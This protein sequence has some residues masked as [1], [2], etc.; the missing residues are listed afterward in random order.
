LLS[1]TDVRG[2]LRHFAT[3]RGATA[4]H[5]RVM[6]MIQAVSASDELDEGDFNVLVG[7]HVDLA[8]R[9]AIT[10]LRDRGAAEDAVQDAALNAWRAL[11]RLRPGSNARAWFLTIVANQ[12][13]SRLRSRW[14]SVLRRADVT[15]QMPDPADASTLRTDLSRALLTLDPLDRAAVFLH[16][17]EDLSVDDVARSLGISPAAARSRIH[18][19]IKQL[20]LDLE[21]RS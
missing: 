9:L 20:R 11:P 17:Y 21:V 7:P 15:A 13:R 18:R 1:P 5:G 2:L 14:W 10:M 3:N 12:C 4:L 16:H 6:A 19:A 8:L